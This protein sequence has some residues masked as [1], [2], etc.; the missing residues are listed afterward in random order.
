MQLYQWVQ[1][2]VYM[3]WLCVAQALCGIFIFVFVLFD[4]DSRD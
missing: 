1:L 2:Q 3:V 4:H